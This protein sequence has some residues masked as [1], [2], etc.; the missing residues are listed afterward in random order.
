MSACVVL[1]PRLLVVCVSMHEACSLAQRA[2]AISQLMSQA[3]DTPPFS[4]QPSRPATDM[5]ILDI[6]T[7]SD[8]CYYR[9]VAAG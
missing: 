3:S 6:S 5:L 8:T 4:L 1:R 7:L 9:W 2:Q